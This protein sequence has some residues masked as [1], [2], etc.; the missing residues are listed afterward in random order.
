MLASSAVIL[1]LS[2][3]SLATGVD[4]GE[5]FL[6]VFCLGPG[7]AG[8]QRQRA[9]LGG[10]G[11]VGGGQVCAHLRERVAVDVAPVMAGGDQR[12]KGIGPRPA[13]ACV[14][15]FARAR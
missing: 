4:S 3:V 14:A 7:G 12:R 2:S 5:E 15:A 13:G 9:M 10:A 8:D 6:E 1:T 11:A